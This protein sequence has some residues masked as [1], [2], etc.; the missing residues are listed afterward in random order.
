MNT[1]HIVEKKLIPSK[2]PESLVNFIQKW[3]APCGVILIVLGVFGL[4]FFVMGVLLVVVDMLLLRMNIGAP[5]REFETFLKTDGE[6]DMLTPRKY[7]P[8]CNHWFQKIYTLFHRERE[9]KEFAYANGFIQV[10]SGTG[11]V[12]E[13]PLAET[14]F[15]Y[16]LQKDNKAGNV[17]TFILTNGN[18]T[19]QFVKV[20]GLF[21]DAEWEDIFNILI[22]GKFNPNIA[23]QQTAWIRANNLA[24]KISSMK[25]ES[26]GDKLVNAFAYAMED[27]EAI[28]GMKILGRFEPKY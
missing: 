13:A 24:G 21:T 28:D 4:F 10:V 6:Y 1:E 11:M 3:M 7:T 19:I 14:I 9:I 17:F 20:P 8:L 23:E 15:T 26:T 5:T 16:T 2:L 18:Q 25:G 12:F 27:K 22:R